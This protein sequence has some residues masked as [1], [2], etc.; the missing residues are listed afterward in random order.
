MNKLQVPEPEVDL[1]NEKRYADRS[2]EAYLFHKAENPFFGRFSVFISEYNKNTNHF[3]CA[4]SSSAFALA[5]A[6]CV[7]YK[8][9]ISDFG[10]T[11]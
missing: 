8:A 2:R 6:S 5:G 9:R 7:Q 11:G 3:H 1:P 10:V 4:G